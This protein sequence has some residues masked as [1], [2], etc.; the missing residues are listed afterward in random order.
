MIPST[1]VVRA[2]ALRLVHLRAAEPGDKV[3]EDPRVL[4]HELGARGVGGAAATSACGGGVPG[5]GEAPAV[6]G[7]GER[8]GMAGG[9]GMMG[10]GGHGIKGGYG[11][12]MGFGGGMVDLLISARRL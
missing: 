12:M 6:G 11:G 7:G 10:M 2:E 4:A 8:N 1:L 9:G 3:A 5:G